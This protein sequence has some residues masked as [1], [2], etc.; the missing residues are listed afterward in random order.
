MIKRSDILRAVADAI[1]GAATVQEI[2]EKAGGQYRMLVGHAA[3]GELQG[4]SRQVVVAVAFGE[5]S[6]D[7][8][9][10]E[11]RQAA[12]RVRCMVWDKQVEAV[13]GR[14]EYE[15]VLDCHDLCQAI[16][17][18]ARTIAN[19]GDHVLAA[20]VEVSGDQWPL[21][22]GEVNITVEWPVTLGPDGLEA[23]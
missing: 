1:E 2:V 15:S 22:V 18:V 4:D 6:Y 5:A 21:A 7:V 11:T 14:E 16:G 17:E 20:E 12:V 23:I 10:T 9:Y 3:D 8:G 13:N 19:M